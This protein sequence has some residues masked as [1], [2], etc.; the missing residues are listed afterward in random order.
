MKV[1][2]HGGVKNDGL[3]ESME[4]I[5]DFFYELTE[6]VDF[7]ENDL[8][9]ALDSDVIVKEIDK[10]AKEFGKLYPGLYSEEKLFENIKNTFKRL[11]KNQG[12]NIFKKSN[13]LILRDIEYDIKYGCYINN[14]GNFVFEA[15]SGGYYEDE[16]SSSSSESSSESSSSSSFSEDVVAVSEFGDIIYFDS[17]FEVPSGM[18]VQ[19][20]VYF[21]EGVGFYR[22][23]E[24]SDVIVDNVKGKS[25]VFNDVENYDIPLGIIV[26]PDG[27]ILE[28]IEN[29]VKI[30]EKVLL[31]KIALAYGNDNVVPWSDFIQLNL[32][33]ARYD[34]IDN[35]NWKSI[36]SEHVL[37]DMFKMFGVFYRARIKTG[38]SNED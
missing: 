13:Y 11:L 4:N 16:S 28:Q 23:V 33:I 27:T 21:E 22:G 38:I 36:I 25:Y 30:L 3:D 2:G 31:G 8:I 26:P 1:G 34:M 17:V 19:S 14:D 24:M 5:L 6:N 32:D 35:K 15:I 37:L 18:Q 9:D 12:V 29:A 7:D 20:F 10:L